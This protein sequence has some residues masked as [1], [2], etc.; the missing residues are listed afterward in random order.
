MN[1]VV[2]IVLLVSAVVALTAGGAQHAV[3][4][5]Q[6]KDVKNPYEGTRYDG[7]PLSDIEAKGIT[8]PNARRVAKGAHR[9]GLKMCC[10]S[11]IRY[12]WEGWRVEGD[13]RPA[14]DRYVARRDGRKV[15]WRF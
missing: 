2:R 1:S 15:S 7:V 4:D 13:L 12:R 3:A 14:S 10:E 6:C 11:Q 5:N 8:C 9:K